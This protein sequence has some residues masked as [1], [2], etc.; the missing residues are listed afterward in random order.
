MRGMPD[1]R[2]ARFHVTRRRRSAAS[3]PGRTGSSKDDRMDRPI[4]VTSGPRDVGAA[5]RMLLQVGSA[6]IGFAAIW[7]TIGAMTLYLGFV[8]TLVA[9]LVVYLVRVF[10]ERPA[11]WSA[12]PLSG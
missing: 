9:G 10:G 12:A 6:A 4:R 11:S 1:L 7:L 8:A 2:R 5:A 3:E